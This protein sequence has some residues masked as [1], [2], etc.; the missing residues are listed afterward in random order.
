MKNS[1]KGSIFTTKEGYEVKIIEYFK[2]N[3]CTIKFNDKLSTILK[4][5]IISNVIK[6]NI[7]NPNH[8][9]VYGVGYVG[10]GKYKVVIDGKITLSNRK[11]RAMI[12]RGYS[13]K[14]KQKQPAYKHITV[15][16]EWYNFQNFAEW[17]EEN[18]KPWMNNKWQL[19]K[20][21]LIK[22][23]KIYSP[24]TCCFVPSEIN[25]SILKR[26]NNRGDYLIGV[27]KRN[28]LFIAQNQVCKKAIRSKYFNCELEAFYSYKTAKEKELKGL[29][30][31]W[32]NLIDPRVYQAMYD[33]KVEITD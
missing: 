18:W 28:G 3:N 11:W 33:Y 29:A 13:Q 21:I 22:G 2:W 12:E 24:E 10:Q 16:E 1:Y 19:D 15:C 4:N 27:T 26:Q 20:D 8:A 9:S 25:N 23:N 5:V 7:K 32:K 30:D 17:F 31:K 6:G 14:L